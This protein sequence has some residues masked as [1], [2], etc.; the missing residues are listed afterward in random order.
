LF[1]ERVVE[2][3]ASER[4]APAGNF[5]VLTKTNYYDWAALMHVMLQARGLWYTMIVGTMDFMEDRLALEVIAKAVPPELMGS[6]ASKPSAMAAWESLV[7]RN[8]G[9]DRVRKAKASTLKREFDSLTFEAGELI[10]DFGT[11]LSRITNQLAVLGFEYKEE[12]IVRRF[13]A[14][15]PPKFEQITTSIETLCDLDTITVDELIGRLKPSEERINRNQG[16]LVAS[17][18]LTEDELVVR[19]SSRLKMTGNGGGDRHKESSSGG[20]K[21]GHGRGGGRGSNSGSRSGGR[22]GGD[23]GDHGGRNAG[24][25]NGGVAKDECCYCGKKGHW[26]RECKKKKCDEESHAVKAEEEEEFTLFMASATVIKPVAAH[27]HLSA[28]HLDEGKLFVQLGE[29]GGGD[30]ARWILDSGATNHMTGVRAVFSEIDLRVHDTVCFGDGSVTNIEGR[31]TILIKYKTGGHKALIVVYYIPRLKAIIVSL[32]QMEEARYK[33]V[34]ESGFLKLWNRAGTLAAKVKHGA[35]RLY[36]L[37][38]DVDRLVCLAAQG[39]SSA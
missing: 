30:G 18:N 2:R 36:V 14:A 25:G 29:N 21:H 12:E 39:T 27:T 7:L 26:A 13:V 6:I 16:K 20:G 28:V 11:R 31:G 24:R 38:L 5:S 22:G 8:V 9:V 1:F 10:D 19:L 15:L 3:V 4:V 32:S 35:S 34:L 37:H 17:L 23:T 33:I